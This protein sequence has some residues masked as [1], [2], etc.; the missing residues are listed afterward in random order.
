VG[1]GPFD[2]RWRVARPAP[3]QRSVSYVY[4][5]LTDGRLLEGAIRPPW[6]TVLSRPGIPFEVDEL[7]RYTVEVIGS[8]R[9]ADS[10]LT[11]IAPAHL[12]LEIVAKVAE[13]QSLPHEHV[14]LPR[15]P[16]EFRSSAR[17]GPTLRGRGD[18]ELRSL[19]EA[20]LIDQ[21]GIARSIL[22]PRRSFSA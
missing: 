3:T 8:I 1:C 15:E 12:G 13:P 5:S 21:P 16:E 4:E 7:D 20:G 11:K 6:A 14:G 10:S 2:Q 9:W 18:G 22:A 19:A 17:S